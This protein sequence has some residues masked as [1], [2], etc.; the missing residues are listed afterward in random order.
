[1]RAGQNLTFLTEAEGRP[2]A[3]ELAFRERRL[4]KAV[5]VG[6]FLLLTLGM[7]GAAWYAASQ[8]R[9]GAALAAVLAFSAAVLS[10]FVLIAVTAFLA[11]RRPTNWLLRA[12]TQGLFI[13][14]RSYLN[15]HLPADLPTVAFLPHREIAWLRASRRKQS[16][17]LP[18][19]NV[20][21]HR[22]YLEIGLRRRDLPELRERL[23]A[24]RAV[25]NA[26][27]TRFNHYPVQLVGRVLRLEWS[28]PR[29]G[30]TPG[31]K[32]AQHMLGRNYPAAPDIEA[33][34]ASDETLTDTADREAR[35]REYLRQGDTVTAIKLAR[36]Y[37][38]YDLTAAKS[39][40]ERL[41]KK[42]QANLEA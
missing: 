3:G 34:L 11:S 20:T 10:V 14:Y 25:T 37:F 15:S 31:L 32:A 42:D 41:E 23:E 9:E 4:G 13:H 22:R 36:F 29:T 38:G 17:N 33:T 28:S 7:A 5:G 18:D 30:I 24:E 21:L 19:D 12:T 2:G 27:A 16:R 35:I 8:G 40:V 6:F 39:Y 1:M 26:A